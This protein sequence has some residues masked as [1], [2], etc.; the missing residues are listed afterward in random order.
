MD[1]C[2]AAFKL[3]HM[4]FTTASSIMQAR[5]DNI[6]ISTGCIELN[7]ILEGMSTTLK[8]AADSA[9]L[10]RHQSADQQYEACRRH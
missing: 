2:F 6:R 1:F 3:V 7:N 8:L 9:V 5:K 4:G 10:V